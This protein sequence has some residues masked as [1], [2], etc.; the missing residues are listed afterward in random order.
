MPENARFP[1]FLPQPSLSFSFTLYNPGSVGENS[2]GTPKCEIVIGLS[3]YLLFSIAHCKVNALN[4][5]CFISLL[6]SFI[7][8]YNVIVLE[9]I[10]MPIVVALSRPFFTKAKLEER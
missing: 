5:L 1:L 10:A 7:S 4:F 3:N 6:L 8:L 2:I 9:T